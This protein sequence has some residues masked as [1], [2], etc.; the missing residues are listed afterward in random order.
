MRGEVTYLLLLLCS[1]LAGI[2]IPSSFDYDDVPQAFS[3]SFTNKIPEYFIKFHQQDPR[4]FHQTSP[5]ISL[6]ISPTRSLN[7]SPNFISKTSEYFTNK[8]SEYYTS[9]ICL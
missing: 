3:E 5:T 6:H 8:I 7:I 1:V 9:N 2:T 4:I